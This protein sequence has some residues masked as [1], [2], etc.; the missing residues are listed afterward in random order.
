MATVNKSSLRAEFDALKARFESLCAAGKMSAESRAL[1]DALLML[2]EL[3]MAV[4]MEKHTPKSSAN[5]SLPA[6][7]SPNDDTARTRPG[8]KGKGPSYNGERCANTR[9]REYVKVLSVDACQR[10]G[11][12]LTD[13]AC[14]GRERRTLIDIVFEKVVR[15]ADAQIKHCPRCHAET[16]ARFPHEMPGPL[17]YGPGIKAYVVHLLIAQMLS[18]KRVAQSMHALIGRTLSEATLLGYVAQLHHALAEW[19]QHAIERLLAMPAMH[20]DET[21]LRVDRKNHWIHVYSAGTLTVKCLHP[22]RGC[23]AIEAIGILP[24][25][26]GVAVHDCWASYLSYAHCDHALCGAHLLRELAFI[27]DAH[28]YAWAKRMKRLLLGACHQ[29]S[30]RDDKTL[31]PSEYKAVQKRY[32]TI[33]T[34]GA[35]ELPPI[36]PRQNGQRGKVAKSDAHNLWE[37]MKN[38]ETAVLRF[39]KH[40]DV[41]FTNNRAERDLR[42]AK[43]KQKVSG[44]F[45]T[46]K[47]A[48][49]YCRISSYLQSMAN[50]GY[51]PLVAIQIALA[52]RAVDNMGE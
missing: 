5:S 35:R 48:E 43:V 41:A 31:T 23:E 25:Y 6:S 24:R 9:T 33:L 46:R 17:Q 34:Q 51:N 7:Q 8:A 22:K 16:R 14:T 12:D 27:V 49:A 28:H 39:A 26:T 36:P 4:F 15:H 3:L 18:L 44:C 2:F 38:Y 13:A 50:Q 1:V 10:C 32:R 29:V 11:E 20:V 42:M 40:P 30:K 21:S 45:R 19:E 52:G 47:Y 37:R